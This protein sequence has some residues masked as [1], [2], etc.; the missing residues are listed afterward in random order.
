MNCLMCG[1]VPKRSI[2][3][4]C[5]NQ[6]QMDFQYLQFIEK[7]KDNRIE[8]GIGISAKNISGHVKRYLREQNGEACTLCGWSTMS[9]FTG[10]VPLEIDHLDGNSENNAITNLRLICP[11]CHSLTGSFR[12]LN[13][14]SGRS[15]RKAK[16]LK[17]TP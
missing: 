17:N 10:R 9:R 1:K 6:C 4:Y 5:S 12:N 2:N 14:G 3:T 7:W 11:N 8:G 15:W 16:Y 13:K